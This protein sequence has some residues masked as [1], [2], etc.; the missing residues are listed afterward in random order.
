MFPPRP[1]LLWSTP[2]PLCGDLAARLEGARR[3]HAEVDLGTAASWNLALTVAR[4]RWA[5]IVH[6]DT[7]V[8]P[9]WQSGLL[10][11]AATTPAPA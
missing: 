9:G 4:A 7:E 1:W 6:E 2:M 8:T 11:C 3:L 10:A 5:A